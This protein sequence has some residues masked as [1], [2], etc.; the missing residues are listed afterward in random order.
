MCVIDR[1][2]VACMYYG[3][4]AFFFFF[5]ENF[6]SATNANI[7]VYISYR[8]VIRVGILA[9]CQSNRIEFRAAKFATPLQRVHRDAARN[10]S[11]SARG[12]CFATRPRSAVYNV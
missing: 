9:T 12:V 8:Y 5:L 11:S 7:S 3:L 2:S 10:P 6:G 1:C 4:S